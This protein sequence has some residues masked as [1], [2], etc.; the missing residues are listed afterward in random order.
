LNNLNYDSKWKTKAFWEGCLGWDYI[1]IRDISL[2]VN[3]AVYKGVCI[4]VRIK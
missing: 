3:E 1:G 4:D 2:G